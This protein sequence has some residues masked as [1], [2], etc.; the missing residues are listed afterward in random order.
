M[1]L[2]ARA[3]WREAVTYRETWPHEYV[4]IQKDG[5][6]ELLAAF[7][8][9]ILQGEGVEGRLFHQ[10]RKY[11]FLGDYKYWTMTEC[12]D[13]DPETYNG[14]LNRALL[15]NDRR[16]FIIQQ[17]DTA[18][19]QEHTETATQPLGQISEVP[20]Q[21]IWPNEAQNFTVWLAAPENLLLLVN[22]LELELKLIE[23]EAQVGQYRLDILA[24]EVGSGETSKVAIENQ[25]K[26]SNHVH[27]GQLIT[28]AA[29]HEAECIGWVAN[30]FNHEHLTAINWL[31]QLAPEK[32]WFYAVEVH[33]IKIGDSLPAPDFR[34]VAAPKEWSGGWSVI[35]EEAEEKSPD[36]QQYPGYFQPMMD[37]L[38]RAGFTS[39]VE[40]KAERWLELDS[41]LEIQG[42][43]ECIYYV[44]GLDHWFGV[45]QEAAHSKAWVYLWFRSGREFV[46][47]TFEVLREEKPEVDSEFGEE[48]DW[49]RIDHRWN[50][51][52][53][54]I[55]MDCFINDPPETHDET[56][57][58]MLETLLK[59]REVF[60]PRLEKVLFELE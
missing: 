3:P 24:R 32:V 20:I 34:V 58:W 29:E 54:R 35:E 9:R 27:L 15:F 31:N 25:P 14:V 22:A 8:R 45:P 57:A 10:S 38:R 59:F 49:W 43:E 39:E 21:Q 41:R 4:M 52:P 11:L 7:C 26:W 40:A 33:A 53:V 47:Q 48:L 30:H 19:R 13:I 2:I 50:I 5:Q 1:D 6:Q 56:R 17:G 51:A 16:D 28:Y 23:T 46:N 60:N 44:V 36:N 18:R 42:Y 37:D 55:S 12:A